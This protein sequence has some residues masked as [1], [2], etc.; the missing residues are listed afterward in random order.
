M[1][2]LICLG[3]L[4]FF[5]AKYLFR[6]KEKDLSGQV[7]LV[8]GGAN[9]LGKE[10]CKKFARLGC[11][12]AVADLDLANAEKTVKEILAKGACKEAH[13]YKVIFG[14]IIISVIC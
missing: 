13:A 9:G 11:K 3:L 12:L 8:T 14:K 6:S 4:T 2:L 5:V 7:V 10:M 1:L